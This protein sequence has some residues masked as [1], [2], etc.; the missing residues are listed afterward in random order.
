M[1]LPEDWQTKKTTLPSADD[2]EPKGHQDQGGTIA[3]HSLAVRQEFQKKGFGSIL[4][5]EFIQRIE[6]AQIADRVAIIAHGHLLRFYEHMGFKN[7]GPSK[8]QFGGG[9]WYD[10]VSVYPTTEASSYLLT[11]NQVYEI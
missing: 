9:G 10:M 11:S 3:L 5:R 4:M 1:A 2:P 8:C 7:K 6:N